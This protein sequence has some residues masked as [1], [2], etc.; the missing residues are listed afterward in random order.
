[1][2]RLR[3]QVEALEVQEQKQLLVELVAG[4]PPE[5][6][7]NLLL[8]TV[9]AAASYVKWHLVTNLQGQDTP[10]LLILLPPELQLAVLSFLD[11]P[12][13]LRASQVS[14]TWNSIIKNHD[15]LWVKQCCRLGVNMSKVPGWIEWHK[16]YITSLRQQASLRNGTAF[17]ERFMQLQNCKKAVK[18]VDYQ[19]GF[20]CTV[21][22]EDYINIWQLDLNIPVLT[23]PVERAVSCIKFRPNSLLLCGHFVGI[24][25]SWDLCGMR[26]SRYTVWEHSGNR[27]Q[28]YLKN[29]FKMHAG[30]VFSCDFSE[31]L[32]LLI[33]GGAD[34]CLKLWSLS[35]GLQV[36]SLSNQ[37]HWVLKVILKPDLSFT[38]NHEIVYMTRE[39]VKKISWPSA[40]KCD[41]EYDVGESV[42]SSTDSVK[43]YGMIE[44]ISANFKIS[45]NE[46]HCNFFTPGLQFSSK[47]IGLIKQ[48]VEEKHANLC[49]F[50]IETFKLKHN[51]SLNIKV[52]KLLALGNRYAL[53]LTIGSVLYSSTLVIIDLFTQKIIGTRSIPHSKMTTPDGAQLVVGD[54]EWLDGLGVHLPG[55]PTSP[56][57]AH[58]EISN[59]DESAAV[60][61]GKTQKLASHGSETEVSETCMNTR[62]QCHDKTNLSQNLMS[63]T[64]RKHES[65]EFCNQHIDNGEIEVDQMCIDAPCVYS[66][67]QTTS[68][69]A[70]QCEC[71]SDQCK[72]L[73]MDRSSMCIS[74]QQEHPSFLVLAAGILNEPG[75]LFTLWW[76][77][78]RHTHKCKKE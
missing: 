74:Q 25:T 63:C 14:R 41:S 54:V 43:R 19:D 32:D 40:T 1:M 42:D 45:L 21:S 22:E 72:C 37:D 77:L 68:S 2:E 30:P 24:L 67:K 16:V 39:N 48:D 23:F 10:D 31:E 35:S 70:M 62:L 60:S 52:K 56:P 61:A 28:D 49:V 29:K 6:Q 65:K 75:R 47:Y 4:S 69:A 8:P 59:C 3:Q 34:E 46:G 50:D 7:L 71:A 12:S 64:E 15:E 38:S 76:A 58:V 11:G 13:L 53:L 73:V 44:K 55:P 17:T 9:T 33:S 5:V 18:A 51:I 57:T 78:S 20:L 66:D 26:Q 36:K 27:N